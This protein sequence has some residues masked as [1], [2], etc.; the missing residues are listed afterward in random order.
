M[1]I[2]KARGEFINATAARALIG[3]LGA[4][5]LARQTHLKPS[6]FRPLES[7]WRIHVLPPWGSMAVTDVR[8]T[9]VQQW[10]SETSVG[11]ATAVPSRKPKGGNV[12]HPVYGFWQRSSMTP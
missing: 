4:E 1:E 11:D 2:F 6:A 8:K 12:G 3:P 5:W 10:V 7:A 9:A